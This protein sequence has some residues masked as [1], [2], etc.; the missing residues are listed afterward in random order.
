[1]S[2]EGRPKGPGRQD[3]T[4]EQRGRELQVFVERRRQRKGPLSD[5]NERRAEETP[6]HHGSEDQ[7]GSIEAPRFFI[8]FFHRKKQSSFDRE[9]KKSCV[10]AAAGSIPW[11]SF[12]HWQW[13]H[14]CLGAE[15]Q[16][17]ISAVINPLSLFGLHR[18]I[19]FSAAA[20]VAPKA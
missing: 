4:E 8:A 18:F 12:L 6:G 5:Q 20:A 1:M 9:H 13:Q 7:V 2:R 19:T 14:I 11:L 3:G 16:A 10:A 15:R 17:F